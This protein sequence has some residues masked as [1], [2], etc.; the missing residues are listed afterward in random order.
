MKQILVIKLGA[1]G[2]FFMAQEAFRAIRHH[3]ADAA[4]T[5]LTI[6]SLVVLARLS[7]LFDE[8]V[9]DP[10]ARTPLAY[11]RVAQRLRRGQFDFVYDLQG[12]RRTAWYW[13]LLWPK[14]P[15]WSGPVSGCSHPR[16]TRP[17]RQSRTE[18][19]RAQLSAVGLSVPEDTDIAWLREDISDL[20]VPKRFALL[21]AGGSAHRPGKRW[22][23]DHYSRI[24]E[25]LVTRDIVP[26]LIGTA[27][28]AAVN[29][30]IRARVPPAL[31][32]SDKTSIPG[33][34]SLARGACG[35]LGNDTGPMHVI[36]ATGCPSVV[37]FSNESDPEFTAP[38][39]GCVQWLQ[40]DHLGSLTPEE[41]QH[42]IQSCWRWPRRF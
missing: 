37:L 17:A 10:R 24:A 19:M 5:L 12:N 1:L 29:Q 21:V 31:D 16:A 33:L 20:N 41:V 14:R 6:P 11:W 13:R 25:M 2:D 39:G 35:A 8:I 22:P 23:P 32:F 28:D 36:A 42:A 7:G 26:V 34:A 18:W 15:S 27:I 38:T 3:H 40:R 30:E 4:I 9:E